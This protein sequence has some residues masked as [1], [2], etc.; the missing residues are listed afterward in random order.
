MSTHELE[1]DR[2][3][4]MAAAEE[5]SNAITSGDAERYMAI[6]SEDAVFMPP[7][8]LSK[9]GEELRQ[10]LREFL[11]QT[12]VECL[13]MVHGETVIAGDLA[14]HEYGRSWRTRPRAGGPAAIA[15]F[16]GLHIVRRQEDGSW[17]LA[18]NIWNVSPT[19]AAPG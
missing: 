15:H 8:S 2:L 9:S 1:R 5:E 7:N 12:A 17:K 4:V 13:Q 6:L 18:R 14:Y 16:K 19:T 10:W 11:G 3:L